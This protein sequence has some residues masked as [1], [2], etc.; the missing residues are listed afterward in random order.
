V[1]S[2]YTVLRSSRKTI[3]LQLTRDLQVLVRAPY[4]LSN[5]TIAHFVSAHSAWIERQRDRIRENALR[6]PEP[7]PAQAE[8]YRSQAKEYIPDRVA[9]YSRLMHLQAAA[10]SITGAKTRFGSCSG[11]NRLSFSWRLMQYPI[12]A[13]D[14]VIVHE[15]AHI[16]HKNHG[17]DF[18]ALIATQLPDWKQRRQL[19]K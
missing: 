11:G 10:I 16:I 9:Y 1:S 19:L 4:S 17:S 7:S 2:T 6:Y 5:E 18:Y 12:E 13:I 3:A 15:L 14:Y 8:C